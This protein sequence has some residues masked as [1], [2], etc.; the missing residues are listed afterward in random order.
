MEMGA[1]MG[2]VILIVE[3]NALF[4]RGLERLLRAEGYEPHAFGS[5]EDAMESLLSCDFDLALFDIRLPGM[6]GDEL[7]ALLKTRCGSKPIAFVTSDSNG[8]ARL[9]RRIPGC[10]VIR[11]PVDIPEFLETLHQLV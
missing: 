11:K 1:V 10:R 3:D 9:E 7:A 8:D 5:A 4:R 2:K 6:N